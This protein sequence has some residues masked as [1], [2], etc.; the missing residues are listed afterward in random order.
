M[1]VRFAL[2]YHGYPVRGRVFLSLDVSK[3]PINVRAALGTTMYSNLSKKT[4]S[5][6]T[7]LVGCST[8]GLKSV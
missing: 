7:N 1:P 8:N 6:L 4:V 3:R 5:I 2:S